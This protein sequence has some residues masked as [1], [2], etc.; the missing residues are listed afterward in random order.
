MSR[1]PPV[2]PRASQPGLRTAYAYCRR[3][4]GQ[5]PEPFAVA[6]HAPRVFWSLA[7]F[8]SSVERRWTKVDRHLRELAVLR[9]ALSVECPWCVDFGEMLSSKGG[10]APDKLAALPA[11]RTS[12]VFT[13]LERLVLE[14]AEAMTATPL[15]VTDELV[16]ALRDHLSDEQVVEL[17]AYIALENSR[18]RTNAA[19]GIAP[20]GYSAGACQ[21]PVRQPLTP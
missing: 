13:D 4:F 20:Q 3:R 16:S 7:R 10:L 12:D 21:V 1:I 19:L 6:A 17:T 18:A 14:Y 15:Q 8:E 11:W 2:T 9:T 5:V